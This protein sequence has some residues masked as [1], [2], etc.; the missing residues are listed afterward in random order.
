MGKNMAAIKKDAGA[1]GVC[2]VPLQISLRISQPWHTTISLLTN[3]VLGLTLHPG[4]PGAHSGGEA[5]RWYPRAWNGATNVV[6]Q[7]IYT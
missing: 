5:Y 2:F 6:I 3:G 4:A 1:L 7:L